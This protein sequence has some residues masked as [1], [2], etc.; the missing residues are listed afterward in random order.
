MKV[1]FV[2]DKYEPIDPE[3]PL[4][5]VFLGTV[6]AEREIS[7]LPPINAS[8]TLKELDDCKLFVNFINIDYWG[9]SGEAV[10]I[11]VSERP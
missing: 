10:E 3:H 2:Y 7:F 11:K 8:I 1:K 4:R 6:I 9:V 5:D